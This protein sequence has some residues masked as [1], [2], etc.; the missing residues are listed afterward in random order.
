M[1]IQSGSASFTRFFVPEPHVA[2]FWSYVD[3]TLRA[4]AYRDGSDGAEA[5]RG[6]VAWEDLFDPS[7]AYSS[8]HKGEYIAFQFRLD[9]KKVPSLVLK[10]YV[11]DA[12]EQYRKEHEGRYPP[13]QERLKIRDEVHTRLLSQVLPQPSGC[14]VVWN[15]AGRWMLVGTSSPKMLEAF[16]EH[17]ER[18]FKLYPVPLYHA[19]WALNLLPL[20][21]R[22]KDTLAGLISIKSPHAMHEGRFLGYEFL[23]WL[24]HFV[25]TEGGQCDFAPGMTAALA[26][27]ERI[28]LSRLDD[29]K[30]RVICT[31]QAGAMDEARTALRQGKLVEEAQWI[32]TVGDNEYIAILDRDLWAFKGLKTPK[33]MPEF[34]EEDPDGR[35]LE[36]MFFLEE[37]FAV[38]NAL[39]QRFLSSRLS[40][41]WNS[42]TLPAL[43]Q[44]IEGTSQ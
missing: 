30:E 18:H 33:Q 29:G 16:L 22:Q 3:E 6:F 27:G 14:D 10:Q 31:T 41:S 35:F 38:W 4:G 21:G 28:V 44:W 37:T 11:R 19:Q 7:F 23:T 5:P 34:D 42:D 13:R 25:E 26:L 8:Y 24:W 2:D 32:V 20:E 40:P 15:P 17:F 36:K 39:F 1:P 43:R 12:V 9:Q